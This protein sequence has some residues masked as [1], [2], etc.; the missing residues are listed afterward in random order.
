[1][2]YANR[3][4]ILLQE[5][6]VYERIFMAAHT[7]D[8]SYL[9]NDTGAV[10]RNASLEKLEDRM[11]Y[12]FHDKRLLRQAVTHTSYTNEQKINR[13]QHYERLEFLGDAVLELIASDFV[14]RADPEMQEGPLTRKRASLVCEQ[15]L[16]ICAEELGVGEFLILGKG[17][18]ATGGR[19]RSSITSDVMEALIGA[20]YLDGGLEQAKLFIYRFVLVETGEKEKLIS[21]SKT[22]LQEFVQKHIKKE[23][24]YEL[25]E[26]SGPEHNKTFVAE[27]T[28]DGKPMGQGRGRTK[29]MAEQ[30]AAAAALRSLEELYPEGKNECI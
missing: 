3:T 2:P 7:M 27:V 22:H 5:Y 15:A 21:D 26:E 29:K 8:T 30:Q 1:M 14:F 9:G 25:I 4:G 10:G 28:V 23:F 19:R 20:I 16:A 18:D 12:R 6:F 17:E 11:G 13:G 24:R